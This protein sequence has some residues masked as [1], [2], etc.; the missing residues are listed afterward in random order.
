MKT[1]QDFLFEAKK[2]WNKRYKEALKQEKKSV[3]SQR[4]AGSTQINY[5]APDA[6]PNSPELQ[7]ALDLMMKH[8]AEYRKKMKERMNQN[9]N[10]P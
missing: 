1:F 3:K 4:K 5:G 9:E 6:K 8:D 10:Q 7:A 2:N